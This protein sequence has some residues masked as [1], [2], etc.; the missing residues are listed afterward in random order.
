MG[1]KT[2]NDYIKAVLPDKLRKGQSAVRF[3]SR[4]ERVCKCLSWEDDTKQACQVLLLFG[5]DVFDYCETLDETTLGSYK[6][7]KK[8]VLEHVDGGNLTE[9]YV[10]QFQSMKWSMGEDVATFMGR[11]KEVANK[12]YPDLEPT[13]VEALLMQQFVLAMPSEVR[14]QLYLA[15][16]KLDNPSDLVDTCKLYIQLNGPGEKGACAKVDI[17]ESKLDQVLQRMDQL[18]LE[19]ANLKA[20]SVPQPPVMAAIGPGSGR[21]RGFSGNCYKCSRFGHMARNCPSSG[22]GSRFSVCSTCG[23]EGHASSECA[24]KT[25]DRCRKCGNAGHRESSCKFK[26]KGLNWQ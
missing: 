9:T 26:G 22:Q 21:G 23:N 2:D 13:V 12:A 6:A 15:K 14:K 1:P 3:F 8:K 17:E 20:G 10:R 25:G 7:L 11:M 18:S 5:D 24:L 16:E 19:V 4:F